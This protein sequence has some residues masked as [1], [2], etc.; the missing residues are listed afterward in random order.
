MFTYL[1]P[2]DWWS[3]DVGRDPCHLVQRARGTHVRH[4]GCDTQFRCG[5]QRP[6][7]AVQSENFADVFDVVVVNE[8]HKS[9]VNVV[10]VICYMPLTQW[11]RGEFD[12]AGLIGT[13]C[14]SA[15]T[16]LTEI[17][18][19]K[20]EERKKKKPHGKNIMACPITYGGHKK[21]KAGFSHLLRHPACKGR[22]PI[23]I[24]ALHKFVTYL[25]RHLHTYLQHRTHTGPQPI[26]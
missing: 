18:R 16:A 9:L 17:R 4:E 23:L 21:N 13:A 8:R 12:I 24:L 15:H 20:K 26:T 7:N 25:L 11:P 2:V 19:G 10:D 5:G 14:K 6:V 22:G 1:E 3:A